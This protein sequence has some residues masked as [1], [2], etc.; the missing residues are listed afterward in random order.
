MEAANI[1]STKDA[2]QGIDIANTEKKGIRAYT[3]YGLGILAF[4]LVMRFLPNLVYGFL[5]NVFSPEAV[6]PFGMVIA[7]VCM[8]LIGFPILLLIMKQIPTTE[9]TRGVRKKLKVGQL[10]GLVVISYG[11]MNIIAIIVSIIEGLMGTSGTV[12]TAELAESNTGISAIFLF[13]MGVFVAPVMEEL[14]FRKIGYDK[15]AAYGGKLYIVWTAIMFGLLHG[16]LGQSIYAGAMGLILAKV[17]YETG[18]IKNTMF[19]HACVNFLGGTGIGSIIIRTGNLSIVGAYGM[20]AILLDIV[21]LVLGIVV[22]VKYRNQLKNTPSTMTLR[23]K[24]M[25]FLNVGTI[26]YVALMLYNIVTGLI[27]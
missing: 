26:V 4:A 25:A 15:V 18:N 23:N 13:I 2:Q 11:V 5:S 24:K 17:M 1:L 14:M 22:L 16:N 9:A 10:I 20:F 27:G 7:Y 12:T 19:I 6:A 3:F 21:G 8:Y